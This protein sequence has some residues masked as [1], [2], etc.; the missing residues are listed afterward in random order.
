VVRGDVV[1]PTRP[2]LVHHPTKHVA[3]PPPPRGPPPRGRAGG[4]GPAT[5]LV[6]WWTSRGRVRAAT[7]PL[8]TPACSG[9]AVRAV[10]PRCGVG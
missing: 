9:W 2:R 10:P 8:T 6:G 4:G 3:A 1:P 7:S 5:C